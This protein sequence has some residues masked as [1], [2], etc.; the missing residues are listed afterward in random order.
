MLF[1]TSKNVV[2]GL[3]PMNVDAER[4]LLVCLEH[5]RVA[6]LRQERQHL[7]H[8]FQLRNQCYG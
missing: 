5:F 2:D 7:Q 4:N 1:T 6:N 3:V 8:C